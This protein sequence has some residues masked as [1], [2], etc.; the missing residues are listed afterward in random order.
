MSWLIPARAKMCQRVVMMRLQED[1][2]DLK[3]RRGDAT[4]EDDLIPSA[5]L[6]DLTKAYPRVNK[7]ALWR[8]LERYGLE[9]DFLRLLREMHETAEYVVRGKEVNSDSF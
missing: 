1:S 2:E 3:R 7:P 5:R 9:G 6:L 4:A 8:L